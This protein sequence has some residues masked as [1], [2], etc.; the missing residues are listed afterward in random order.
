MQVIE[1]LTM[2][3]LN[4]ILHFL[5][6]STTT[7]NSMGLFQMSGSRRISRA[8]HSAA[9]EQNWMGRHPAYRRPG[10]LGRHLLRFRFDVA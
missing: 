4:G 1:L 6:D 9:P 7:P 10:K 8:W 3:S 5:E 2:P